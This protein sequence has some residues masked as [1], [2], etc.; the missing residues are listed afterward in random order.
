[1][2]LL[3]NI[4]CKK[5]LKYVIDWYF[6]YKKTIL[7][8]GMARLANFN[9]FS[10]RYYG[11]AWNCGSCGATVNACRFSQGDCPCCGTGSSKS[12]EISRSD[13]KREHRGE[14]DGECNDYFKSRYEDDNHLSKD[15]ETYL[16]GYEIITKKDL[17]NMKKRDEEKIRNLYLSEMNDFEFDKYEYPDFYQNAN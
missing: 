4:F 13:R 5:K 15:F 11:A 16:I 3:T 2:A 14:N 10:D 9:T 1:M 17:F 8:V 7:L 12:P 6:H